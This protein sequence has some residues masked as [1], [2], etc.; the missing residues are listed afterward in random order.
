VLLHWVDILDAGTVVNRTLELINR[1]I[2]RA[3]ALGARLWRE[4]DTL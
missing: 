1:F 2:D 4:L 3:L